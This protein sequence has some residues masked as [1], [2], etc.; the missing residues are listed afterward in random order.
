MCEIN[1]NASIALQ[2]LQTLRTDMFEK[3][4][5][6]QMAA[7]LHSRYIDR[8]INALELL[9][10]SFKTDAID[11][12]W[13]LLFLRRLTR[14]MSG[15]ERLC[16]INAYGWEKITVLDEPIWT[17]YAE[18]ITC[19]EDEVSP[20]TQTQVWQ[21]FMRVKYVEVELH[22]R[23]EQFNIMRATRKTFHEM[24]QQYRVFLKNYLETCVS[25]HS[26]MP[27]RGLSGSQNVD[28]LFEEFF[29]VKQLLLTQEIR[30]SLHSVLEQIQIPLALAAGSIEELEVPPSSDQTSANEKTT[31]FIPSIIQNSLKSTELTENLASVIKEDRWSVIFGDPGCGK[32]TF[33]RWLM[34]QFAIS[35]LNEEQSVILEGID[36]QTRIHVGPSRLPV[37]IRVGELTSWLDANP[38]LTMIDYIGHQTWYGLPYSPGES[39]SVLREFIQHQHAIILIDGLDEVSDYHQRRRVVTLIDTFMRDYV[40]SPINN[41]FSSDDK[42]V[43]QEWGGIENDFPVVAGGNQVIITSRCIGYHICPLQTKMLSLFSLQPLDE[44]EFELFVNYWLQHVHKRIMDHMNSLNLVTSNREEDES[45]LLRKQRELNDLFVFAG[46]KIRSHPLLLSLACSIF[47]TKA[48]TTNLISRTGLYE[49]TVRYALNSYTSYEKGILN[50]KEL[51][52]LFRDMALHLHQHCPSGLVDI[53][54]LTR[55]TETS[56]KSFR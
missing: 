50:T 52:W 15:I 4:L 18:E 37:L 10:N 22:R 21:R 26:W 46:E 31:F 51:E 11:K 35:V 28:Q 30:L 8:I 2:Q 47:Y 12:E 1:T 6:T 29:G 20:Q 5:C 19:I 24:C 7:F 33:L 48:H 14:T 36:E 38:C 40:S 25:F 53:F 43:M 45:V 9:A 42:N 54:D 44:D 32:T 17:L 23:K 39:A 13:C 49:L 34:K 27:V 16:E 55:L 41:I 56:L 3:N